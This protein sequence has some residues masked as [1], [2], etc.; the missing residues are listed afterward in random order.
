MIVAG[1]IVLHVSPSPIW[2]LN[3][4]HAQ[5]APNDGLVK[6]YAYL[7]T[8]LRFNQWE[9]NIQHCNSNRDQMGTITV[10][11]DLCCTFHLPVQVCCGPTWKVLT[12]S[13]VLL[14]SRAPVGAVWVG[15]FSALQ[16]TQMDRQMVQTWTNAQ[17]HMDL[18]VVFPASLELWA[19]NLSASGIISP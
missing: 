1:S 5:V 12:V 6:E 11:V 13:V 2:M 10:K 4:K 14:H 9:G 17:V 18:Q 19:I 3:N 15:I 8:W 16:Q 7:C